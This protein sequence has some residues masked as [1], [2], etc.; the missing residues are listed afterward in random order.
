VNTGFAATTNQAL[1]TLGNAFDWQFYTQK[2][3]PEADTGALHAKMGEEIAHV[4]TS[5]E[6]H[7]TVERNFALNSYLHRNFH[8]WGYLP[9]ANTEWWYNM[10]FLYLHLYRLPVPV[11]Y[12]HALYAD[13]IA[14]PKGAAEAAAAEIRQALKRNQLIS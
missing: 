6:F 11:G 12:R 8:H 10:L 2:A 5:S 7:V 9:A 4:Q 14:R 3:W 13:W 1:V